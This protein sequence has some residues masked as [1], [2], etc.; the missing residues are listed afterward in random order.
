MRTSIWERKILRKLQKQVHKIL[1]KVYRLT[2]PLIK[3]R[4]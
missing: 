4:T 3:F 2:E 1:I